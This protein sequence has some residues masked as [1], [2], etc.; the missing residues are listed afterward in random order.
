MTTLRSRL[1]MK[2]GEKRYLSVVVMFFVSTFFSCTSTVAQEQVERPP[3]VRHLGLQV[4][5]GMAS[6]R[7]DLI[8]PLGFDGPA[9]SLGADYSSKSLENLFALRFRI[10]AGY[11]KNRFSHEG[12]IIALDLRPSWL[13]LITEDKAW[14]EL[15]GGLSMPFQINNV[16][17]GSWDD[18][19]LYWLTAHSLAFSCEWRKQITELFVASVRLE[20]PVVGFVSRPSTYRNE[21]QEALNHLGYHLAEPNRNLQFE[22]LAT[23]R[24]IFLQALASRELSGSV[25][26]LG[27]EFQFISCDKPKKIQGLATSVTFVYQWRLGT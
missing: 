8:V 20:S 21:K 26:H 22:S 14:G 7:D 2:P 9:F 17:L 25:Y 15:W 24:A 23:Y 27:V 16:F 11:V 3:A 5:L 6:I 12:G 10:G 18:A 19:H 4:S 13:K 1:F